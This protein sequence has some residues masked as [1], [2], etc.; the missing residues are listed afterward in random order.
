MNREVTMY[1]TPIA[2]RVLGTGLGILDDEKRMHQDLDDY[3]ADVRK[4]LLRNGDLQPH[5]SKI[6]TLLCLLDEEIK[7]IEGKITR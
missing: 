5:I 1:E 4:K 3:I 6:K 2:D 7:T